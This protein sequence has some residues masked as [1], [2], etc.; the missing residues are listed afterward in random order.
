MN[1]HYKFPV[2]LLIKIGLATMVALF[3]YFI[4][5]MTPTIIDDVKGMLPNETKRISSEIG[6]DISSGTISVHT[7][8]HGGFHGDG[9]LYMEVQFSDDAVCTEI[10]NNTSWQ[11]LPLS[12]NLSILTYGRFTEGLTVISPYISDEDGNS[13]IPK[14]TNGYYFF[15]DRHSESSDPT[16]DTN[17]LNRGSYNFTLAI[18]DSDTKTLYYVEFDT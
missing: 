12:E 2:R 17:V 15:L 4:F 3:I 13:L 11:T 7:D 1:R 14:I 9:M 16:D 6:V 18:Y 5:R 8:D 10:Q